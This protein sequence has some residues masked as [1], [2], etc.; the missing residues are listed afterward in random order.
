MKYLFTNCLIPANAYS[1]ENGKSTLIN[2]RRKEDEYLSEFQNIT[3]SDAI[4]EVFDQPVRTPEKP[5]RYEVTK[6]LLKSD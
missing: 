5:S 2:A 3:Q 6:K 4:R 1:L